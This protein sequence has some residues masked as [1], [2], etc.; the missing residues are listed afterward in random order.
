MHPIAM[1]HGPFPL[2]PMSRPVNARKSPTSHSS[3]DSRNCHWLHS[4]TRASMPSAEIPSAAGRNPSSATGRV[5][6]PIR[7]IGRRPRISTRCISHVAQR[8]KGAQRPP[9][10]APSPCLQCSHPPLRR[11][12]RGKSTVAHVLAVCGNRAE[13]ENRR[14]TQK[15]TQQ[16]HQAK[17]RDK[18]ARQRNIAEG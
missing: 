10:C 17:R 2:H 1:R 4:A 5:L 15:H 16:A 14:H 12:H 11:D 6:P 3:P 18:L 8:R 9:R 7:A 13:R